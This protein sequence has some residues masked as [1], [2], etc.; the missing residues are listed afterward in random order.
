MRV[1]VE[2]VYFVS[3]RKLIVDFE[4][5]L[6]QILKQFEFL[7]FSVKGGHSCIE[8]LGPFRSSIKVVNEIG[9][10]TVTC[11]FLRGQQ[12]L[13]CFNCRR[14]VLTADFWLSCGGPLFLFAWRSST[15]AVGNL[16]LNY[17]CHV[18]TIANLFLNSCHHVM[19]LILLWIIPITGMIGREH[20][21]GRGITYGAIPSGFPVF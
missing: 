8:G 21:F 11:K 17:R 14:G 9:R 3:L 5:C 2:V 15:G 13:V 20:H 6:E 10:N 16:F 18:G 1:S 19:G 7:W 12:N 4:T